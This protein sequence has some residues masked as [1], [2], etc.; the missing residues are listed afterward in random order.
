M[1]EALKSWH[2]TALET[3]R[4]FQEGDG[5][6]FLYNLNGKPPF[7]QA[8]VPTG[9]VYHMD[10]DG[11]T[12]QYIDGKLTLI[13]G[14]PYPHMVGW[15]AYFRLFLHR[16]RRIIPAVIGVV[17]L[18][19]L[20]QVLTVLIYPE[21][22]ELT[23]WTVP[24]IGMILSIV[25]VA[26][27]G[28]VALA[29]LIGNFGPAVKEMW[30]QYREPAKLL[31]AGEFDLGPDM[32]L[33]SIEGETAES[34]QSRLSEALEAQ[35]TNGKWL[36][37]WLHKTAA[38]QVIYPPTDAAKISGQAGEM[39]YAGM[40]WPKNKTPFEHGIRKSHSEYMQE[41]FSEYQAGLQEVCPAF[42]AWAEIEK[43]AINNPIEVMTDFRKYATTF[44]FLLCSLLMFG[45][46][47]SEQVKNY[48]GKRAELSAPAG[49]VSF[50]FERLELTR[51]ANGNH[52]WLQV[53]QSGTFFNN[54]DDAGRLQAVYAGDKKVLGQSKEPAQ[55]QRITT[56]RMDS[57]SAVP[58]PEEVGPGGFW[59]SIPDSNQLE[60]YKATTNEA[61]RNFG[62]ELRPRQEFTF[63]MFCRLALPIIFL[64]WLA[65]ALI[66]KA[67]FNE[68]GNGEGVFFF[69]DMQWW[70]YG[71]RGVCFGAVAIAVLVW[72]INGALIDFF[73]GSSLWGWMFQS[74]CKGLL[75]YFVI[76]VLTPNPPA[77][78]VYVN[79]G[80]GSGGGNY[81]ALGKG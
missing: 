12:F 61:I 24:I 29:L 23:R 80:G 75:G 76:T 46:S 79:R 42:V 4:K 50:V 70:G 78:Y 54:A 15:Y 65:S 27:A 72:V 53:L 63:W 13:P 36:L 74:F 38:C 73:A 28:L 19:V 31:T 64:V 71:A 66:A 1:I 68:L 22:G 77:G 45:Q 17:F 57:G 41:P 67:A 6:K 21:A 58:I 60:G 48:L 2:R 32:L 25:L 10:F 62:K 37:I 7:V 30:D 33:Q 40:P 44:I 35:K 56:A 43:M 3:S 26:M 47:K 8:I 69:R 5:A 9:E 55:P 39:E 18:V 20:L 51:T 14:C 34:Y 49:Q 59:A 81:K 16:N 52:T 11:N